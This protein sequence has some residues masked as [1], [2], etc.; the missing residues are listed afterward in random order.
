MQIK[1]ITNVRIPTPRAHGY[2]IIKMCSEFA[3]TGA[4]IELF[5]PSRKNSDSKK[6]PFDFY[7]IERN[8]EIK[9]I[10]SFDFIG[11][12]LK[13]GRIFY[14]VDILSFLAMSKFLVRLNA[15]DILYTRDFIIALFFPKKQ[16]I[17]LELHDIPVSNFLFKRVL[18][19]IKL[20]F[21]LNTYI[22]KELIRLGVDE[23][24]IYITPSGVAI[25]DF[26]ISE[27]QGEARERVSLPAD[28][29]L[30]FYGG[31][32][33]SW[34]GIKTLA[35]AASLLPEVDFLFVGGIEPEYGE[36]VKK[37]GKQKNIIIRPFQE[38]GA[39]PLYMR[40]AD[41]LAITQSSREIISS[42]Y[43]SP[44]KMFEYMAARKPIIA[45]NL[46]SIKEVLDEES[47]V[48]AESDN[49]QSFVQAIKNI[50]SD[51]EFSNKIADNAY[52][53]VQR[54]SWDKR[55]DFIIKII[56]SHAQASL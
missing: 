9:K 25:K 23:D 51:E 1:Y 43:S 13:F 41:I 53:R 38:R 52:C 42:H 28:R 48:F 44:L 11:R 36:F 3:K 8:F 27:S 26:D 21:V 35:E 6:D 40:A 24:I 47:A 10:P 37:Y 7:K 55:A 17:C 18:K 5:I 31:Q 46:L 2:A 4:K 29:K 33:Y 32:F 15:K 39:M 19:K 50:L 12:T 56:K 45:P 16:F 22:K 20:F 49:P 30:V 14:W 54:Y 34:K